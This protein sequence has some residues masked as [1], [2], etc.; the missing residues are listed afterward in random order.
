MSYPPGNLLYADPLY[1]T[2]L[3]QSQTTI[4]LPVETKVSIFGLP[5]ARL[6]TQGLEW[7]L[8]GEKLYFPG[9]TS[10][11]NKAKES[12]ISIQVT[13]GQLLFLAHDFFL[14]E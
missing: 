5:E 3:T 14:Q 9:L 12:Q 6:I 7:D 11:L 13:E 4:I 2:I 1:G 8:S 10:C